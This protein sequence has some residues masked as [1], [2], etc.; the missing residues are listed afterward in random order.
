MTKEIEVMANDLRV[1]FKGFETALEKGNL[2]DAIRYLRDVRTELNDN[3]RFLVSKKES[4][5]IQDVLRENLDQELEE[6]RTR[7]KNL[8]AELKH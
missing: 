2:E 8:E 7:V 1:Y 6:Y 4:R 5:A 3:L